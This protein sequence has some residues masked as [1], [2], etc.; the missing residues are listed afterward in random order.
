MPPSV[1]LQLFNPVDLPHAITNKVDALLIRTVTKINEQNFPVLP[2]SLQFIGSGSAGTDHVD[3][4][5]LKKK[6][7]AFANAAGCNARSVAEYV[8]VALLLWSDALKVNVQ[9]YTVGIIGAGATGSAVARLLNKLDVRT[10]LYDPPRQQREPAFSSATIEEVL[11]TNILSF[12]TPLTHTGAYPTYHWL[13]AE[14]LASNE[15]T[16][17]INASRGGVIDEMAL[18]EAKRENQVGN[19][20]MDVWENEPEFRDKTAREAFIKT[21]H[22]AGYSVQAKE[23]ASGMIAHALCRY[24][25]LKKS[26]SLDNT[27]ERKK[28]SPLTTFWS[29]TDALTYFHPIRDYEMR[30]MMLIGRDAEKKIKGFNR[31]RTGHPLRDEFPFLSIPSYVLSQFPVLYKL[32]K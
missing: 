17:I 21:P 6:N 27:A 5:Y 23:R 28:K 20:V 12:H 14:R 31:I 10:V 18:L 26:K 32:M 11:A 7:I 4:S 16:L 8:A 19:I 30:L 1:N 3:L 29:L 24:F 13:D 9:D 22:I 2:D 25:S 15:F